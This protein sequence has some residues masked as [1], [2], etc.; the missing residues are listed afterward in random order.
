MKVLDKV[1]SIPHKKPFRLVAQP[2]QRSSLNLARFRWPLFRDSLS[3]CLYNKDI[4][5]LRSTDLIIKGD[6][7]Y[8]EEANATEWIHTVF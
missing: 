5:F 6:S 4:G 3:F 8:A 1:G 2:P 7:S